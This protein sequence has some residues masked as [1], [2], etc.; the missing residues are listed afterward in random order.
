MKREFIESKVVEAI[1]SKFSSVKEKYILEKEE[2]EKEKEDLIEERNLEQKSILDR[3]IKDNHLKINFEEESI[4]ALDKEGEE[5]LES[6]ND[7]KEYYRDQIME[8][9]CS[10]YTLDED[11]YVDWESD[12]NSLSSQS[13][14]IETIMKI[15]N[16]SEEELKKEIILKITRD[17]ENL[18]YFTLED[19]D[20]YNFLSEKKV[21]IIKN[22]ESI[23]EEQYEKDIEHLFKYIDNPNPDNLLI[24]TS[25]KGVGE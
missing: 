14:F 20:T 16:I 6:F 4:E 22:I 1:I 11:I 5:C 9:K 21:I 19:L 17:K 10:Y 13:D 7:L 18:K 3:G 12:G 23:K 15:E 8:A 24:I 2:F 25:R